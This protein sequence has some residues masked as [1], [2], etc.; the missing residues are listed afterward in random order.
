VSTYLH[1]FLIAR[2]VSRLLARGSWICQL[3]DDFGLTPRGHRSTDGGRQIQMCAWPTHHNTSLSHGRHSSAERMKSIRQLSLLV[4][5]SSLFSRVYS[6]KNISLWLD[7]RMNEHEQAMQMAQ[8]PGCRSVV[9]DELVEGTHHVSHG[10]LVGDPSP[11]EQR[12]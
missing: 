12:H 10:L 9:Y 7:V 8:V 6:T 4:I 5:C 2:Q 3:F 11:S 1:H